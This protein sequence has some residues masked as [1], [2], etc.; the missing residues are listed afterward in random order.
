MQ[1][2]KNN[3]L[4]IKLKNIITRMQPKYKIIIYALLGILLVGIVLILFNIKKIDN[5]FS[6]SLLD[7]L[8]L[9]TTM[10]IG[11]FFTYIVSVS[12][13]RET[14]ENEVFEELL[15]NINEDAKKLVDILE[16]H[17]N[18][19]I[20]EDLRAHVL[21]MD[22]I[23][24]ADVFA[25][26]KL[27]IKNQKFSENDFSEIIKTRRDFHV[28]LTGDYLGEG[29]KVSLPYLQKTLQYYYELQQHI[30]NFKLKM[31]YIY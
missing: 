31:L 9:L 19:Q 2:N 18:Q 8:N 1:K 3:T 26:R 21:V 10:I 5:F 22:G 27:C 24:T 23:L 28:V 14:K 15:S 29:K 13:Q 12:L 4:F 17:C 16:E 20:S 6:F 25:F 11:F 7:L 30:F